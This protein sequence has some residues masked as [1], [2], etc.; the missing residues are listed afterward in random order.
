MI[1]LRRIKWTAYLTRPGQMR[2]VHKILVRKPVGDSFETYAY[3]EDN[4][5][6]ISQYGTV[7]GSCELGNEPSASIKC[8]DFS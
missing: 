7:L 5:K 2:N 6:R 3:M 4:I 1:T 8:G